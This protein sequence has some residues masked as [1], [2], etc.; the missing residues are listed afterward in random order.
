MMS[1]R[2]STAARSAVQG[3]TPERGFRP[4]VQGLRAL[5]VLMVAAYHIWLGKVSGGVDVF[6]LISAFL[7]TLS[8]TRKLETGSPLKLLRHWLHV[9]K[10]LL[11]AVVV[12]L[13][14]VLAATWAFIP[15]S[16]WPDVLAEAWASLFYRQN[17]QLADNA[18]DYYAQNHSG[19]SP[20]QHFWSLS[21]QG[22]VFILWPLIFAAVALLQPRLARFFPGKALTHRKLL[23]VVFGAVFLASLV[24]SIDQTANNQEYAYF[25]TRARLWEF[26]LGSLLALALPYLKPGRKLRVFLGWAGITAMLA[27]GL[28]LTVDRSFPGFI[29]L[30]PTLAAAAVIVAG[31]SNSRFGADRFLASRPLVLVGNNSYALYLWHWPV[32]V[33]FLLVS[34]TTA[35]GLFQGLG[36]MAVSMLLAVGTT[37]F[38]EEP[39]RRWEWPAVRS[40]RAAVVIAACG[41][42]LAMPVTVWQG[43]IAAEDA[44]IA[45]QPKELTPGAAALSPEFAGQPAQEAMIIPAPGAMKDEWADIDGLCTGD[46]VPSDPLLQGCL[47]NDKPENVTKEIVVLGDSHAQQYMAALGPIAKQH[48]WEVVTLLK[49]SCRFGAESP[50]RT[51][52]CNEFNKASANYVMEHKP[53][54]VFTVA[55]LTHA[56]APFETEVPGYLDGIKPFT[57]AGI[58]VVGIRD[59]PRFSINM[60][61][62]VQKKGPDSPD[63]NAPLQ[64]SL[65]ESSPLDDYVGKVDRLYLMDMSDFICEQGTCPAVVGNVY[66]YK[67][68]NHLTKTYVQSMIPMFEQRLLAATGWTAS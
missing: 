22:Q 4:E 55:S 51:D 43:V 57:D 26:A 37:R 45:G 60:P 27:C 52:E 47:Q 12:V 16:R 40:W 66:V 17:W 61:E 24:F 2:T 42:L 25:D 68:D 6:L 39:M 18:V 41:A 46:N 58:D 11:P 5:A 19:A 65:A 31:Q 67:D 49:G 56:D 21:V 1:I 48:G 59:N 33:F 7:L 3:T 9:F 62:C 35:P 32:L 13:L 23:L 54:A 8:F 29:A 28:V 50:E 10:R 34:G 63:C 38:V 15:Q 36:I 14:G 53:D 30:W 44:A 20:L 64:E